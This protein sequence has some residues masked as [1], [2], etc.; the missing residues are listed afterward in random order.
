MPLDDDVSLSSEPSPRES[1]VVSDVDSEDEAESESDMESVTEL[2]PISPSVESSVDIHPSAESAEAEPTDSEDEPS[3]E[4]EDED[5]P[6]KSE[7]EP[8]EAEAEAEAE[9]TED[10][11]SEVDAEMS[12]ESVAESNIEPDAGASMGSEEA[13]RSEHSDLDSEAKVEA[14]NTKKKIRTQAIEVFS[15]KWES[16]EEHVMSHDYP[17]NVATCN[18]CFF[19][20]KRFQWGKE[21]SCLNPVTNAPHTWLGFQGGY[22]VCTVCAQFAERKGN[23]C[24]LVSGCANLRKASN[25]RR[26]ATQMAHQNAVKLW[27]QSMLLKAKHPQPIECYGPEG[28]RTRLGGSADDTTI[29]IKDPTQGSRAVVATR[30]LLEM[31]GPFH[32]FKVWRNALVG[33]NDKAA[34]ESEWHCKRLVRTMA[35]HERLLTHSVLKA[36]SVFR[37][38]ADGLERTYQVEVGTVLWNLPASLKGLV[39]HGEQAGWLE[40]LSDKGPWVVD[41]IIGMQEFSNAMDCEAKAAMLHQCVHRACISNTGE[42][43]KATFQKV[44]QKTRVWC[45]DG[46]DLPV[47]LAASA[48]FPN[49]VFHAWDESHSSQRLCA[50]AMKDVPEADYVDQ[51]LVTGRK[52]Y[53][54]AKFVHTSQ[55]MQNKVDNA[56]QAQETVAWVKNFG[57]APQRFNSRARPYARESR[58]WAIIFKAVEEEAGSAHSQRRFYARRFLTELG[59]ENSKRLVLGGLLADLSA[60]HYTWVASGDKKHPVTTEVMRRAEDFLERLRVLFQEGAI[61]SMKNSYT[62]QTLEFLK[63]IKQY[64]A[65]KNRTQYIG[66]G[67]PAKSEFAKDAIKWALAQAKKVVA[68]ILEWMKYYRS[69]NSWLH[70]FTAFRLPSPLLQVDRGSPEGDEVKDCLRKICREANLN[71][72]LAMRQWLTLLPHAEKEH[73]KGSDPRFAWARVAAKW[74]EFHS[75]RQLLEIYFVWKTTSGNLERRFRRF[76]EIRCPQRA[77]MLDLSVE[78]CMFVEQAPSSKLCRGFLESS[79]AGREVDAESLDSKKKS[80]KKNYVHEIL[81]LHQKLHPTKSL[82]IHQKERRDAG[83]ARPAASAKVRKDTEAAFGRKRE[84]A[85]SALV[86]AE[87]EKRARMVD[88][89]A[90]RGLRSLCAEVAAEAQD[91]QISASAT[92]QAK[93]E[94]KAEKAKEQF[95]NGKEAAAK[96][97]AKAAAKVQKS[98]GR[99]EDDDLLKPALRAGCMLVRKEDSQGRTDAAWHK[100]YGMGFVMLSDPLE[101]VRRAKTQGLGLARD[102]VKG[103]VVVAEH[104]QTDFDVCADF[105]AAFVGAFRTTGSQFLADRPTGV[106]YT[107]TLESPK[108]GFH[109][110]LSDELHRE[111]PSLRLLL[112][113]IATTGGSSLRLYNSIQA[114]EKWYTKTVTETPK[115]T[116]KVQKKTFILSSKTNFDDVLAVLRPLYITPQAFLRTIDSS[117]DVV[118]PGTGR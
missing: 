42:V 109:L 74:P 7:D 8:T 95:Q 9:S 57:W 48:V 50:N 19:W 77:R 61:I 52:P 82:R 107:Q 24:L 26:H 111:Y 75:A 70:C 97:R 45:S 78:N 3:P 108:M 83:V 79:E 1:P 88:H 32:E 30:A 29:T 76:R 28:E 23:K 37:L 106:I 22:G 80:K 53:S 18:A 71:T 118:C 69:E 73:I 59:G 51:L 6:A 5:E 12:S 13:E 85:V 84:R 65:G 25:I 16:L 46:Q 41:R 102:I 91:E 31:H 99:K 101:F 103:H 36:G 110:T 56:Q 96:A 15:Q 35:H 105:A 114:L 33:A 89:D 90:P 4:S 117:K 67:D 44:Q 58:R 60:E 27:A 14:G 115:H 72:S 20:Q 98:S 63:E 116:L 81:T 39:E 66:I 112:Q 92:V 113:K 40:V 87:P 2:S 104:E 100:G 94:Q 55:V 43:D 47:P 17:N 62:G 10:S 64:S 21:F 93:V 54:L 34:L 11:S 86:A 38:Q 49:C 68:N